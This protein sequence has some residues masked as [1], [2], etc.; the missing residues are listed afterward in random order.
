MD[1]ADCVEQIIGYITSLNQIVKCAK[2]SISDS[3]M[4]SALDCTH[5]FYTAYGAVSAA[6]IMFNG[7]LTEEEILKYHATLSEISKE[8]KNDSLKLAAKCKCFQK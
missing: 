7:I 4:V 3:D 8:F 5:K 6:I 2:D 1:R